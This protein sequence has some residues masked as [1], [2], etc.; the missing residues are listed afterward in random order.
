MTNQIKHSATF[1][2]RVLAWFERHGRHDLPWQR[3][4]SPYRVWLS[5][6]M[7]QQTQVTTVIPYFERFTQ[8][9]PTLR[10]LA[11]AS[12]DDVLHLW[13]G[14]GYYARARNLYRAARQVLDRGGEFPKSVDDL[15]SLP[16]IGRSTAGA[17]ISL[18]FG[19]RAAILD[20]NVKR[21]L[22]R[23]NAIAGWPGTATTQKSLWTVAEQYTPR[24]RVADYNQAMMDLGA[25]LCVRSKPKCPSCPVAATCVANARDQQHAFP[26]RKTR[27]PLPHRET[28]MWVLRR[29]DGRILLVKR[30]E[31]GV[32]GGLW[33]FP[34]SDD[35]EALP[36]QI[37]HLSPTDHPGDLRL[38]SIE[39]TFSH[40][41]L[42]IKPLLKAVSAASDEV[43]E[44][45]SSVWI[46]PSDELNLGVAAP[47][48]RLLR[49]LGEAMTDNDTTA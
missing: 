44:V 13:T 14:L 19:E 4:R 26:G 20:G 8:R 35:P 34:E 49:V 29:A 30:P 42:T 41:H 48:S 47:V 46:D 21:V 2:P 45:N 38:G 17:I 10:D 40:Y 7:L 18:A 43:A 28:V 3:D 27:K 5:E 23:H 15:V 33:S 25:T 37:A 31:R 32:W 6:I 22:A 9:F 12:E 24:E 1:A 16:G 39:H 36:S 11:L